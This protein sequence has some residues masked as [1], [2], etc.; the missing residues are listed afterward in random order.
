MKYETPEIVNQ[1]TYE[2]AVLE[3]TELQLA[4]IG[5]GIG[6]TTLGPVKG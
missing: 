2:S 4:L 1:P 5:G 6:E 3:L